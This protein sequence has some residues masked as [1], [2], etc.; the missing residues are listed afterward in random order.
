MHGH[1][2]LRRQAILRT[3]LSLSGVLLAS[4]PSIAAPVQ[5]ED[6][7]LATPSGALRGTLTFS[8]SPAARPNPPSSSVP[9]P[10]VVLI[11]AGSGPTDRDGNGPGFHPDCLRQLAHAL[12]S[13]GHAVVRYDK[14]GVGG[15]ITA[16]GPDESKLRFTH[17]VDDASRWSKRLAS[18]PRFSGV[19]LLG[20]SEGALV[21]AMAAAR[22]RP[23]GFVS[24]GGV[25]A[26]AGENLRH[27]LIGKLPQE[28]AIRSEE[29]LSGLE[30]GKSAAAVPDSLLS[31]YRPT[32]QPYLISWFQID[33]TKEYGQLSNVP[34]LVVQG[35]T[36]LQVS[37]EDARKLHKALPPSTLSIIPRMNH[38]LKT[39][40]GDEAAQ[41][42]SYTDPSSPLSPELVTAITRFLARLHP[43]APVAAT[44]PL[45]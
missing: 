43:N 8:T 24:I 12:A 35:D 28:L 45:R 31:L 40:S 25:S 1:G 36:D 33:P 27:Q 6:I 13:A 34:T 21:A 37:V 5:E 41:M 23:I 29:I 18:D 22:V 42:T 30:H 16:L 3:V 4:N 19:V 10:L 44:S 11:N 20:H 7:E 26:P 14:R 17:Y 15:S 2:Q 9:R 32:V 39:V 38:V